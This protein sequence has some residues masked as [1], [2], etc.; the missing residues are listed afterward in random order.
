VWQQLVAHELLAD[1]HGIFVDGDDKMLLD[2]TFRE[3]A[4]HNGAAQAFEWRSLDDSFYLFQK[5]PSFI[6]PLFVIM[7]A[8]VGKFLVRARLFSKVGWRLA[9][10]SVACSTNMNPSHLM[11]V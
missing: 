2:E 6:A 4:F 11:R 1:V 5:V 9:C 10:V 3:F 7:I 8:K